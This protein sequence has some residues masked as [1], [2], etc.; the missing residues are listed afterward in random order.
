L[1]S[2][3]DF[4]IISISRFSSSLISLNIALSEGSF[5]STPP[6]G[7]LQNLFASAEKTTINSLF[8]FKI[9]AVTSFLKGNFSISIDSLIINNLFKHNLFCRLLENYQKGS[10]LTL[11]IK[12]VSLMILLS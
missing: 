11:L 10:L 8:S 5:S 2:I 3:F 4:A 7:V 6:A 9:Y 1:Y 12:K